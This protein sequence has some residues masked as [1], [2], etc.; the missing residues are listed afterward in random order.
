MTQDVPENVVELAEGIEGWIN[1]GDTIEGATRRLAKMGVPAGLIAAARLHYERRAGRIRELRD[2]RALVDKSLERGYWYGGS[3]STD[4]YWPPLRARLAGSLDEDALT[5]VDQSSFKIV[6]LLQPPGMERIQTR[7]LVLG[8]VQS[9]KTTNFMSVIAKAADVGY[10]LFIVLSGI[11][12]NLRAQTQ[13]RLEEVLVG[14][15]AKQWFL[16]TQTDADF[17][18]PGNASFLLSRPDHKLLA[19]VKKNPYRLRRLRRWLDSAGESTLRS[20]PIILIDDEADQASIDVGTANRTSR[21]NGLIRQIL[22]KPKAAY[23]AYTATPF[24]NLLVNPSE[25]EDIYPRDFV[26]DL[27]RPR[28]YL[29]PEMIFGREPLTP[30]EAEADTDD[31]LDLVRLIPGDEVAEVQPPRGRGAVD[32]WEPA[33]APSLTEAI[34]WFVLATAARRH[35]DDKAAH[36]TMLIHTSMLATAHELLSEPVQAHLESLRRNITSDDGTE[37]ARLRSLWERETGVVPARTFDLPHVSWQDLSTRIEDVLSEAEVVIDNYRSTQ[38]LSYSSDRPTTAIVIGGNTLSRG[39]TLEGLVC[40]YF[41]RAAS[42]YDTLLQMGRWF[43]YRRGYEDLPRIWMTTDL[44]DWFYDLATVEEEVRR[45]IHRYED[46][47]LKPS[48]LPVK[49]RA[50][51]AMA[52]TSAAKMRSAV[53]ARISFSESREQTILFNHRDSDWLRHNITATAELVRRAVDVPGVELGT[54]PEGRARLSSVPSAVVKDYLRQ[55]RFHDRA[56]RM[57]SDLLTGYINEQNAQ[58]FLLEWNIVVI[59]H[60]ND[61]NGA[62]DLG[63]GDEVNLIERSRLDMPGIPHVN[64]KT[65]VTP[66][67]RVADI[68]LSTKDVRQRL[69]SPL[70]D[71]RLRLLRE[72]IV[73]PTGLLCIYPISKDSKPRNEGRR[74]PGQRSRLPLEAVEHVIGLGLFFPEARGQTREYTYYAADLSYEQTEAE[75]AELEAIDAADEAAG[76]AQAISTDGQQ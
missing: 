32:T 47:S 39:L 11:T 67:D 12:D 38:R 28:G 37:L 73:G 57:R 40:S 9:G 60:P 29:G 75:E 56:Y 5:S 54:N 24:A 8:Y 49:I 74:K 48:E 55:Y 46:E 17:H 15:L 68:G 1:G 44:R 41:V 76:E 2:P 72:D 66:I 35:R 19:V 62:L 22:G 6:G 18:S 61:T 53:R 21:I 70:T 63:L 64:I 52:I 30:E 16:L 31:G 14:D 59:S 34:H 27:P 20:C 43:G 23:V 3:R 13:Q 65:L 71:E 58:G 7:G 42:A 69:G 10:R 25:Y 50:H 36:S 26:V 4:L 51:P 33:L 45:E